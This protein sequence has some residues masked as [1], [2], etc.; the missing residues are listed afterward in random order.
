MQLVKRK[1]RIAGIWISIFLTVA[2]LA[3][4]GKPV[5]QVLIEADEGKEPASMEETPVLDYIKP[6]ISAG[7]LTDRIGYETTGTKIIIVRGENLPKEFFIKD[8]GSGEV[9]YTGRLEEP[10]Y[11]TENAEYISYGDFTDFTESGRYYAECRVVGKS[12]PFVVEETLYETLM[13]ETLAELAAA[14]KEQDGKEIA[15]ICE[16]LSIMLLSYELFDEVYEDKAAEGTE[17]QFVSL[18]KEYIVWLLAQQ[19]S[20]TGAICRDGEADPEGTAWF[21]AVLAK[22]SYTYQKF[23]STYATVC[24]QAADRAWD[25]LQKEKEASAEAMFYAAAELYRATGQYAYHKVV[26]ELGSDGTLK[27]E[28]KAQVLGAVTYAFTKRNVNVDIC[29]DMMQVLFA[30]A[31]DIAVSAKKN[32]YMTKSSL[33]DGETA[34]LWDMILVATIDYVITNHEYATMIETHLHYLAGVNEETVCMLTW[35]EQ[36]QSNEKEE[37]SIFELAGYTMILSEILSHRQEE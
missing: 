7:V 34:I 6:E 10:V 8:A 3:G 19:D 23:D 2:I 13:E 22:F 28:C 12:Y 33:K 24:L 25:Y 31:E 32:P 14:I 17:T 26:K 16:G 37:K 18:M 9:V 29:A 4:C 27:T 36:Y 5:Q 30:E 35:P 11:D 21:S 20:Q 15:Q 1:N